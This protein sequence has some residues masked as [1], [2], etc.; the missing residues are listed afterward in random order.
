MAPGTVL[1]VGAAGGFVLQGL[2]DCGWRGRGLEPNAWMASHARDTLGI[3]VDIGCLESFHCDDRFQLL[4]MIQVIPHFA[5]LSR[6]LE[7]AASVT[8]AEGF[9]LVETWNRDSWTARCFGTH[10]HEYSPPS[11]LHWF[12][13]EGLKQLTGHTVFKRWHEGVLASGCR[14]SMQKRCYKPSVRTPGRRRWYWRT[15]L[16]PFQIVSLSPI[17]LRIHSGC[18]SATRAKAQRF[19]L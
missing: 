7:A 2:F 10:W 9:W 15:S 5:N 13:P 11:V 17:R 3:P 18:C 19:N 4:T 6:A 12:S 14:E 16:A 1:D 8:A